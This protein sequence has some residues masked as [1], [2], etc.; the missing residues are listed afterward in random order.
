MSKAKPTYQDLKSELDTVLDDLQQDDI[1]VDQTL[2][3]YKR[4]LE[5]I[6]QLSTQLKNAQNTITELQAK[7]PSKS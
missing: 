6:D 5:L 2:I 3:K 1:D 4:G 7:F